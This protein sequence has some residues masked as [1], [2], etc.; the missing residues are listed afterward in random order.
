MSYQTGTATSPINLLQTIVTWLVSIGWT[1]DMS[2]S[3]GAGWRAHLHKSGNFVNLRA[4]M[5][6][7]GGTIW[8]GGMWRAGYGI[9]MYCG[10][11]FASG[12][13][14]KSQAGGPIAQG[15][16]YNVGVAA[17]LPAGSIQNYYFFGDATGDNVVLVIEQ[18]PAV[19]N[20]LGFGQLVKAGAW[21][22]GG[23]YFFGSTSGFGATFPSPAYG[24]TDTSACPGCWDF[25]QSQNCFV[26]ADVDTFTGNWLAVGNNNGGASWGYTGKFVQS[27]VGPPSQGG[28]PLFV[29]P[30][31]TDGLA[32][33]PRNAWQ[34]NQT[35]SA[36]GR[37]NLLPVLMFAQ[38]DSGAV[39]LLGWIPNIFWSNGVGI[40]FSNASEYVLG[41]TTYKMFPNFAVVKQ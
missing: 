9:A 8:G 37:A 22:P 15:Q 38:R 27:A 6:E 14:W 31:Y 35:S 7:S 1:Q 18:T 19:Y 11:G 24:V 36:D 21:T 29:A 5:N 39:S 25:N 16:T 12:S 32:S 2:Q 3:D 33:G 10:S 41:T 28:N 4:F 20:H 13:D 17:A 30:R 23:A 40:G 26:R 34:V